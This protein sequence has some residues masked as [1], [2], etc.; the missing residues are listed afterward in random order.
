VEIKPAIGTTALLVKE[1]EERLTAAEANASKMQSLYTKSIQDI[2]NRVNSGYYTEGDSGD[3][4]IT[5]L[6]RVGFFDLANEV[7][8]SKYE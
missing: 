3:Q 8:K 5:D 2:I 4:L 7:L 1:L 6:K